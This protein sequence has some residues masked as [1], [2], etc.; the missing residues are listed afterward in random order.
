M[1]KQEGGSIFVLILP[2]AIM[3]FNNLSGL[4]DLGWVSAALG[5]SLQTAEDTTES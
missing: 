4:N 1:L 5:V 3:S 2:S